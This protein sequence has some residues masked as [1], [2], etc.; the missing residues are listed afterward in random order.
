MSGPYYTEAARALFSGADLAAYERAADA[1]GSRYLR[2]RKKLHHEHQFK[3][4]AA[5]DKFDAAVKRAFD[6]LY[7]KVRP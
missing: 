6:R 3:L 7:L 5:E 2:I 1:A 4:A